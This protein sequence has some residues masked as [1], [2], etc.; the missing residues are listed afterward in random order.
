MTQ[1]IIINNQLISF[2]K[3]GSELAEQTLL[4][5]HGWRSNKEVWNGVVSKLISGSA[6]KLVYAIDLPGFGASP[7]PK[8]D[9]GVSDYAN[10]VAEF[11][12]KLDLKNVIVVGHSF[13]GRVG[14]KLASTRTDLVKKLVLVD[15]AGFAAS[16][17]KKS[18]IGFAAKIVKPI[19]RLKFM[20]GLRKKIYKQIGAEDY[21]ATPELQKIFVKVVNED[22]SENMKRILQPTLIVFGENDTDTP[23]STG[24][25][26]H[27]LILN[28]S[29][30]L[31]KNA[32]HFSFIDQSSEF[33]KILKEFIC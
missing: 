25:K 13:G 5:L 11:I 33:I 32:G 7:V 3:Q 6:N 31:L 14:I 10:L 29:F 15:A 24:E 1:Q 20:Q 18:T 4:F 21:V 27:S 16:S 19:F 9:W 8:E 23:T 22:L 26:M 2:V 30:I 17:A 28:S 12:S